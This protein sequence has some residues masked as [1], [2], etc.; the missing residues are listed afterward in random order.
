MNEGTNAPAFPFFFVRGRIYV[1]FLLFFFRGCIPFLASMTH[2]DA[3]AIG[4]MQLLVTSSEPASFR[5]SGTNASLRQYSVSQLYTRKIRVNPN[6]NKRR[7]EKNA[8]YPVPPLWIPSRSGKQTDFP[9][10][11]PVQRW[12]DTRLHTELALQCRRPSQLQY[13]QLEL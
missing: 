12:A 13:D 10:E 11:F 5:F 3:E 4:R 7:D 1:L 8:S 6:N 9:S 2:N